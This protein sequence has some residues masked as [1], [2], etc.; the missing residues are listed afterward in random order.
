MKL[1]LYVD[2]QNLWNAA[3]NYGRD[4]GIDY[5]KPDYEAILVECVKIA[6][7][8]AAKNNF[9]GEIDIVRQALY[10]VSR[11]R[12]LGFENALSRFG[13]AVHN[14]ILR[15][16]T[17]NW[18]WDTQIAVDVVKDLSDEDRK[19][20]LVIIA[21]GDGDLA[22][23]LEACNGTAAI[24]VGFPGSTSERFAEVHLLGRNALYT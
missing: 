10:S 1:A 7:Q 13:Y 5:A 3:K 9:G 19:P 18:D 21:S 22:P 8:W 4:E 12:A 11:E 2:G 23:V 14:H 16:E 6:K 24:A 17:D 15:S 20:D